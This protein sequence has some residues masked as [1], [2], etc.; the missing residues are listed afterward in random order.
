MLAYASN[1]PL[2]GKGESSPNALL[3]IISVHV[4]LLAAVMSSKVDVARIIHRE[5][6]LIKIPL[7]APDPQPTRPTPVRQQPT[8][9]TQVDHPIEHSK[10]VMKKVGKI[11]SLLSVTA[12]QLTA[13]ALVQ[14][15]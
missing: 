6:P 12:V 9:I 15:K 5:P 4:A 7:P 2:V 1:R 11:A 10:P 14:P 13:V 3:V 8:H